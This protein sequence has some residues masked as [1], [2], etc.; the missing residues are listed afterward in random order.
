MRTT[1]R[2]GTASVVGMSAITSRTDCDVLVIGAGPTGLTLAA[3]LVARGVRT[4]IIDKDPGT[5]HLS[6]AIG[7]APRTLETLDMMGIADR[8]LD[9]G[10]RVRGVCVY[11]G[12]RRLLGVDMAYSGSVYDFLLHL[13]Q[14]RTEALLRARL[15]ELGGA[16]ER[17]VEL[18]TFAEDG[19]SVCVV[20]SDQTGTESEISARFA[21]GCDGAHSRVR[22][23]LDLPFN[24]QPYPWDW[25]LAD[26]RLDW[27]GRNDEVHVFTRPKGMPLVCVPINDQLWRLS[28]PT[29]GDRPG[30]PTLAEVQTLV[31]ERGPGGI[32]VSE[33]QT[34]TSFRCQIRSTPSYRHGRVLLAGD[35][36]HVH[37]PA[38]GQGMNTGILD[39]TNLAW[40]LHLVVTGRA[41]EPLLDTYGHERVPVAAQVMGFTQNM[42]RFGTATGPLQRALRAPRTRALRLPPVQR[43]LAGRMAQTVIGYPDSPLTRRGRARG[44]PSPG[45]RMPDMTVGTPTGT[46]TLYAALRTGRHVLVGA[47]PLDLGDLVQNITAPIVPTDTFVLV[48]PDGYVAVVG[49]AVAIT[50]YWDALTTQPTALAAGSA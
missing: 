26:A 16:V 20:V 8:F 50:A 9:V 47:E 19:D 5:A 45:A 37:S 10:H 49:T 32:V 30:A 38:G 33:P 24:G 21:V 34:L 48:R 46:S 13:P 2:P 6:R 35:A 4:R 41:P 18:Q 43:R 28:L 25:Y 31:D 36:A 15:A 40:K 44:L 11:V 12:G 14:E 7:I 22:H 42:V 29:P 3:Q 39:A 27:T 17:G 23:L 1:V